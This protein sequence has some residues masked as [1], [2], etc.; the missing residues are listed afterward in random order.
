M[1][2]CQERP[3]QPATSP[4]EGRVCELESASSPVWVSDQKAHFFLTT[5]RILRWSSWLKELGKA[6]STTIKPQRSSRDKD[7]TNYLALT[8]GDDWPTDPAQLMV[9]TTFHTLLSIGQ[10]LVYTPKVGNAA[11]FRWLVSIPRNPNWPTGVL[12]STYLSIQR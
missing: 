9:P 11:V 7:P 2:Q 8:T 1:V 3:T 4:L 12:E 10:Y 6:W 5:S